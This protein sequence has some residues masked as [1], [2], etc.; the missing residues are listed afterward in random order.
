MIKLFKNKNSGLWDEVW[1]MKTDGTYD[2][3]YYGTFYQS[4][5]VASEMIQ[6]L[7]NT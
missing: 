5:K 7:L 6:L 4:L 2:V 1:V 3:N